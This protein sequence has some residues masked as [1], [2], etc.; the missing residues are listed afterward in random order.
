TCDGTRK[1]VRAVIRRV[2][3][4]DYALRHTFVPESAGRFGPIVVQHVVDHEAPEAL[5][6]D[7]E[8]RTVLAPYRTADD[9]P[10]AASFLGHAFKDAIERAREAVEHLTLKDTLVRSEV[11]SWAWPFLLLAWSADTP[12][13]LLVRDLR[14]ELLR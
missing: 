11:Q 1:V 4:H 10:R 6:F 14:L 2:E 12:C 8:A 9:T 13:M 5:R 3:D 7:L